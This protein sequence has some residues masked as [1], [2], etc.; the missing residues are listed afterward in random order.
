MMKD[1]QKKVGNIADNLRQVAGRAVPPPH[2]RPP[3]PLFPP[4]SGRRVHGRRLPA[5]WA[6]GWPARAAA[7]EGGAAARRRAGT[8][9]RP[10]N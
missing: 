9:L 5:R 1:G 10:R 7:E 6:A 4:S 3:A 2:P 8:P